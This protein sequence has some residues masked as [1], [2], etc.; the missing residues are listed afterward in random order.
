MSK[1]VVRIVMALVFFTTLSLVLHTQLSAQNDPKPGD[2]LIIPPPAP[3]ATPLAPSTPGLPP[4]TPSSPKVTSFADDT[5][6]MD[7]QVDPTNLEKYP[8]QDLSLSAI[9]VK[10]D[11]EYN[12]AL[13]EV[14]GIGY[15]VRKG[16]KVG[17]GNGIVREIT[18]SN[19]IIEELSKDGAPTG[20]MVTLSFNN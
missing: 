7:G 19:V 1:S 17:S 9:V 16:A 6:D 20:K 8:L 12:I 5:V 18:E 10:S 3:G 4:A 11:P 15:S 13:L 14:G 2:E